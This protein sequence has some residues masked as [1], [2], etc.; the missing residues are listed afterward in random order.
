MWL[1]FSKVTGEVVLDKKNYKASRSTHKI[2][3]FFP[4]LFH[5]YKFQFGNYVNIQNKIL[6]QQVQHHCTWRSTAGVLG[7]QPVYFP[8]SSHDDPHCYQEE[9][10]PQ[11]SNF[12]MY[13]VGLWGNEG[14][15]K[16]CHPMRLGRKI[17]D[18]SW[19][20]AL[21]LLRGAWLRLKLGYERS[22]TEEHWLHLRTLG[23]LKGQ[24][25]EVQR[26]WDMRATE[27]VMKPHMGNYLGDRSSVR[28]DRTSVRRAESMLPAFQEWKMTL[29][30]LYRL[31]AVSWLF[32]FRLFICFW[33]RCQTEGFLPAK[34]SSLAA[35]IPSQIAQVSAW[36]SM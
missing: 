27:R 3:S 31:H 21:H 22:S 34:L 36:T 16:W 19:L 6:K 20:N 14:L 30:A 1:I 12:L 7:L 24:F 15:G 32:T 13:T 17:T 8:R 29:Q 11:H 26:Y 18:W 9:V 23:L 5:Q 10:Q 28:P 2:F 25:Q 33:E 4:L 35:C